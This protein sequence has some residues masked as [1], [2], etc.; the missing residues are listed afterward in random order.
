MFAG[1]T[2]S[3]GG[4]PRVGGGLSRGQKKPGCGCDCAPVPGDRRVEERSARRAHQGNT[5]R[6]LRQAVSCRP[7]SPERVV[8]DCRSSGAV[9]VDRLVVVGGPCVGCRPVSIAGCAYELQLKPGC[10]GEVR[11]S[12]CGSRTACACGSSEGAGD[13]VTGDDGERRAGRGQR[14]FPDDRLSSN[15]PMP[16]A[17]PRDPEPENRVPVWSIHWAG[18]YNPRC[19]ECRRLGRGCPDAGPSREEDK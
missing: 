3:R 11:C 12:G 16:L 19:P 4:R 1:F 7:R 14:P 8:S 6:D 5:V 15:L 10:R 2:V 17:S 9:G 18:P 13:L